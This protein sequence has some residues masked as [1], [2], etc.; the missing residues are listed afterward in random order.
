VRNVPRGELT[1][2]AYFPL[3]FTT[4]N[5]T[6]QEDL[7]RTHFFR[8]V[9]LGSVKAN[10]DSDRSVSTILAHPGGSVCD[11]VPIYGGIWS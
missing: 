8:V 5:D 10:K 3:R 1:L 4:R 6:V 11:L 7:H 2:S 9:L